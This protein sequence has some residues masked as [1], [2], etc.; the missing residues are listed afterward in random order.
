MR[1]QKLIAECS[2]YSRRS[3]E[4]LILEGR[5]TVDAL[6]ATIGQIVSLDS[7][8]CIDLQRLDT[9]HRLRNKKER[10]VFVLDKRIGEVCTRSDEKKRPTVFERLPPVKSGRW[11][12]VGRLD[13]NTSGLL[14]FTND[15]EY[16]NYL[17]HPKSNIRR[18]YHVT[19]RG[20]L[21]EKKIKSLIE[22]VQLED[23]VSSFEQIHVKTQKEKGCI[24]QVT[25]TSGRNRIVR[26]LFQS[27]NLTVV[28]LRRISYGSIKL[29]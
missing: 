11:I 23:G 10:E 28:R 22:G 21:T 2:H 27:Q 20:I 3:A 8:V 17:M 13:I 14:I 18:T 19:L 15:G 24:A 1:I 7:E 29:G 26:R 5:V 16:A 12:M 9:R 4:K 6:P 25:T